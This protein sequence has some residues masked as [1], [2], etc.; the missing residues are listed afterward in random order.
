MATF[1]DTG[2]LLRFMHA[3]DPLHAIVVAAVRKLRDGSPT[4]VCGIQNIAEFWNVTTRPATSRG[5]FGQSLAVAQQR[6]VALEQW[7]TILPETAASYAEWRRLIV[8]HK[9]AGVQVHDARLVA[10]MR[11]EGI[12]TLLTL[13]AKDFARY[14]GLTV[15]TPAQVVQQP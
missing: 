15:L 11:A 2:V 8:Q 4:F 3:A 7:V 12:R 1:I 5:G 6:V 14:A 13:N 9:V 10:V